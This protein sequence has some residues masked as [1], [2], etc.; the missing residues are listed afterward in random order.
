M[1]LVSHK[2]KFIYLK[3]KK[4]AGTSVE[5]F[6]EKFCQ[7]DPDYQ[8][9]HAARELISE[10]GIIG[11]RQNGVGKEWRPHMSAGKV[12]KKVGES[13]WKSYFKFC[14]MR[15]PWDKMVSLYF[16]QK[17]Q[18]KKLPDFKEWLIGLAQKYE[19]HINLIEKRGNPVDG[20]IYTINGNFVCDSYIRF[21]KLQQDLQEVCQRLELE[22]NLDQLENYKSGVREA[23]KSYMDYYDDETQK[24]VSDM[25][26]KEIEH[27]NYKFGN[28]K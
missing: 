18:K 9:Q 28:L 22:V 2:H 15:N 26:V 11:C 21:E 12:S 5:A 19:K 10:D 27:F 17:S 25:F 20:E 16:F 8:S 3:T 4:T 1:V 14:V 23:G 24:V 7:P 13:I 6:F